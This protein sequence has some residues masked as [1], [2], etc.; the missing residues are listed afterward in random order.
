MHAFRIC[1]TI[2]IFF[3]SLSVVAFTISKH[4][5]IFNLPSLICN[6]SN[7]YTLHN[8]SSSSSSQI[9]I[10]ISNFF[11]KHLRMHLPARVVGLACVIN[12]R[13]SSALAP[14]SFLHAI[15]VFSINCFWSSNDIA[16]FRRKG[17]I[18][19]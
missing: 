11:I 4:A 1:L 9:F 10:T 8:G 14:A 5:S 6:Q 7:K 18:H 17:S 12:S 19:K 3:S 13:R 15:V 16:W 2:S